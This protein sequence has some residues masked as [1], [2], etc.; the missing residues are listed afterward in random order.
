MKPFGSAVHLLAK[1]EA[2]IEKGHDEE[3]PRELGK[4]L[5]DDKEREF[6]SLL[7]GSMLLSGIPQMGEKMVMLSSNWSQ[8]KHRWPS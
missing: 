1:M 4:P 6:K 5:D 3:E 2:T 7:K 8:V